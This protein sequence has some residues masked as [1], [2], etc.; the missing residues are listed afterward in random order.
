MSKE[1]GAPC[2]VVPDVDAIVFVIDGSD[3]VGLHFAWS[4]LLTVARNM[5]HH[6]KPLLI[7]LTKPGADAM[8]LLRSVDDC[9]PL[10][11]SQWEICEVPNLDEPEVKFIVQWLQEH[12]T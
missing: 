2:S 4:E 9:V 3:Y 8:L 6:F 12:A 11:N 10:E 1:C 7:V 5:T